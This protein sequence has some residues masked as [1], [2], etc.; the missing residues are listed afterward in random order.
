MLRSPMS[1]TRTTNAQP[2]SRALSRVDRIK[3]PK[4]RTISS[5]SSS[6]DA[7]IGSV[8][9]AG[10]ENTAGRFFPS[11]YRPIRSITP[12]KYGWKYLVKNG[13]V[14]RV[15]QAN[16]NRYKPR[17]ACKSLNSVHPPDRS[18][19]NQTLQGSLIDMGSGPRRI[20]PWRK[21]SGLWSENLVYPRMISPPVLSAATLLEEAC[22]GAHTI[23]T[24][25]HAGP[26]AT[27]GPE[28]I[29]IRFN[30][31]GEPHSMQ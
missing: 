22:S 12:P 10:F 9:P 5:F 16:T 11:G 14:K 27:M 8:A 13:P 24:P 18:R 6:Q 1:P 4:G 19:G 15:I 7:A 25:E 3:S 2:G 17:T 21:P 20:L 28:M 26:N 23:P 30:A 31:S 29:W